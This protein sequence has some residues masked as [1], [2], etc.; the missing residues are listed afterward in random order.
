MRG[1]VVFAS[2]LVMSSCFAGCL[3]KIAE[4]HQQNQENTSDDNRAEITGKVSLIDVYVDSNTEDSSDNNSSSSEVKVDS[5]LVIARMASG[6]SNVTVSEISHYIT[7]SRGEEGN[8]ELVLVHGALADS[9]PSELDDTPLTGESELTAGQNFQF[10]VQLGDCA[11][12]VGDDLQ[13]RM[14]LEG[15]GETLVDLE[16]DSTEV[17]R[18]VI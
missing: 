17:G 13:M 15:G 18:S 1:V 11:A 14:T 5:I 16:V 9:A 2:L 7:C 10:T 6:S 12:A 8:E 4:E 3:A